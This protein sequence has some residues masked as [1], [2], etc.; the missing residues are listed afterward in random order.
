MGEGCFTHLKTNITS[1]YYVRSP[2]K[3]YVTQSHFSILQD[4]QRSGFVG[5]SRT[6]WNKSLDLLPIAVKLEFDLLPL[7]VDCGSHW[8]RPWKTIFYFYQYM[9]HSYM[10]VMLT[11]FNF[12]IVGTKYNIIYPTMHYIT[13][14]RGTQAN[15]CKSV[16]IEA[17]RQDR[18]GRVLPG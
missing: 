3:A 12:I 15:S 6:I 4:F 13:N 9:C 1:N 5:T 18:R 7:S 10:Y 11:Y 17:E 8:D 16:R 14:H 2:I